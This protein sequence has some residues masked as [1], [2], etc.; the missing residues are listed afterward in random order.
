MLTVC[1]LLLLTT[2]FGM[3]L[4]Y[5]TSDKDIFSFTRNSKTFVFSTVILMVVLRILALV[6]EHS[7]KIIR[8]VP[9]RLPTQTLRRSAQVSSSGEIS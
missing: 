2:P 4:Q 1:K 3:V 6:L 8:L 7:G 9:W 5:F